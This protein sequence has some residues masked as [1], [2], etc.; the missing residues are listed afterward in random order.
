M[1]KEQE[2]STR[3]SMRTGIRGANVMPT[4]D[5]FS[6]TEKPGDYITATE[7]QNSWERPVCQFQAA[8]DA[9]LAPM[10]AKISELIGS[11]K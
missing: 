2:Q 6:V 4:L 7:V 3:N 9:L 5:K 8:H 10:I 1:S 11:T